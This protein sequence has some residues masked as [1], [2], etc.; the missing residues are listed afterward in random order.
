[1]GW[2]SVCSATET[3]REKRKRKRKRRERAKE[4]ER[5]KEEE[6]SRKCFLKQSYFARRGAL[7]A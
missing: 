6:V 4:K 3:E 5:A 2:S 7:S 1:M